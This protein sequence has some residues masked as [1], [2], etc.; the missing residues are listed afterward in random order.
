M[1]APEGFQLASGLFPARLGGLWAAL[2]E[3]GPAAEN[4]PQLSRNRAVVPFG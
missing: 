4:A 3:E 1:E 2:V